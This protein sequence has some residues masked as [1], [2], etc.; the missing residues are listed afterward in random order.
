MNKSSQ[1]LASGPVLNS[2]ALLLAILILAVV[3]RVIFIG[4]HSLWLDELFSLRFAGYDLPE[5]IKEVATFDNHPPTYYIL[6]HYWISLFGDSE[7][8]LRTPSAIFSSLSVFIT[9]KVGE[10][11]FDKRVA[12]IA[13][14]LLAASE[15]SIYYAQEAR[16]YSFLAFAA[17][18]SVY[19]LLKLLKQQT[20]WSLFNYVWSST[21]LLYT[22]LYGIFIIVAENIYILTAI[23]AFNNKTTGIQIKHWVSAQILIFLLSLPWFGI[24]INRVLNIGNEGFW[25]ETPAINSVLKTFAAYSG[26]SRGLVIWISLMLL[27]MLCVFIIKTTFGRKFINEQ[28]APNE[29]RHIF[30]LSLLL[31]TPIVLPYIVSQFITPVYII[32]CTIAGHFAFYLLVA[33]GIMH[34]RLRSFRIA[35]MTIILL[36]SLKALISQ[37]YV[38]HNAPEF[39]KAVEY[40][41]KN[42]AENDLVILCSHPH[43]DWPFKYYAEKQNISPRILK[44]GDEDILPEQFEVNKLWLVSLT[45]R[46]TNCQKLLHYIS[47]QYTQI[48]TRETFFRNL[49][50]TD[51]E[52]K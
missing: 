46:T 36:L 51:F 21:L 40:L 5:L 39:K 16:M 7:A 32:R 8:S 17:V 29:G 12:A 13:G 47:N 45:D 34:I 33:N 26:T 27:G 30:L 6:L 52:K 37:G 9:Y 18:L 42:T 43:L 20:T 10:L 28:L 1:S 48:D 15:F 14:L 49:G 31:F 23:Y 19:F 38:H 2:N 4:T 35:A 50:L 11:L 44:V 24:L 22:H 25:V 3:L 41:D